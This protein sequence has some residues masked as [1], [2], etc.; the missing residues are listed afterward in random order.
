MV[1]TTKS[2]ERIWTWKWVRVWDFKEIPCNWFENNSWMRIKW[3]CN[4]GCIVD[5]NWILGGTGEA[6]GTGQRHGVSA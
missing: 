2:W 5:K 6:V 4:D 1:L 3:S